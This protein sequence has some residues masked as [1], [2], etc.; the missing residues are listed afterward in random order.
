MIKD[1][2]LVEENR[3]DQREKS[4]QQRISRSEKLCRFQG[5]TGWVYETM[6]GGNPRQRMSGI[7]WLAVPL[8]FL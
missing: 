5:S 7:E 1:N 3:C 4:S 2:A 6:K 8:E